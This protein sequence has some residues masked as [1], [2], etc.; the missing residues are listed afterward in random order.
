MVPAGEILLT[1]VEGETEEDY[2]GSY[3]YLCPSCEQVS[4]HPAD[5]PVA[6]LLL[7]AGAVT[8]I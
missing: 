5:G 4:D 7:A 1:I 6:A 3:F 8:S 2:L